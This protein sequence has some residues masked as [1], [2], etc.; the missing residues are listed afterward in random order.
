VVSVR[1]DAERD[2]QAPPSL[3]FL[4]CLRQVSSKFHLEEQD[5]RDARKQKGAN[6][7]FEFEGLERKLDAVAMSHHRKT[8]LTPP[9][10]RSATVRLSTVA[11][12]FKLTSL[13]GANREYWVYSTRLTRFAAA[14]AKFM[15]HFMPCVGQEMATGHSGCQRRVHGGFQRAVDI[16]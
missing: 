7:V 10:L 11:A 5:A 13:P 4:S 8:I 14:N 6:V 12:G 3:A 1:L 9:W 2:I 16:F 15:L